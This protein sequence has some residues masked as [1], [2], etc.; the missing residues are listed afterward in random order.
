[1]NPSRKMQLLGIMMLFFIIAWLVSRMLPVALLLVIPS[2]YFAKTMM[3]FKHHSFAAFGILLGVFFSPI[4]FSLI[5]FGN[6][7]LNRPAIYIVIGTALLWTLSGLTQMMISVSRT[8][9]NQTK[10]QTDI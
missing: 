6:N 8:K 10:K 1:M 9:Q 7:Y 3:S 5:M 2:G 4:N